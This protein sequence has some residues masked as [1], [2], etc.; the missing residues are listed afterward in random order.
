M[1]IVSITAE[2]YAAMQRRLFPPGRAWRIPAGG[3]IEK[4]LL[5]AG[6]ELARVSDRTVDLVR[7]S[8]SAQTVELASHFEEE[9]E[10]PSTGTDADRQARIVALETQEPQFRPEDIRVAL[11]PYLAQDAADVVVIEISRAN[12]IAIGVDSEIYRF[13][14]YRDP[15][16]PGTADIAAAQ[17]ELDKILHSNT[18]GWVTESINFT[19][20]DICGR[21]LLGP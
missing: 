20:G 6:D 1:G 15:A 13:H 2:A 17:I 5:A 4:V 16:L 19:A 18:K 21:D 11:A 3:F 10:L 7:E 14:V 12:A 9:L 8:D